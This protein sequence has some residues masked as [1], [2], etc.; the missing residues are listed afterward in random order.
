MEEGIL[1]RRHNDP[2]GDVVKT[3]SLLVGPQH[4]A[5][6]ALRQHAGDG[7][8]RKRECVS[9]MQWFKRAHAEAAQLT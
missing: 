9:R 4:K 8:S 5:L 6:A 7:I 1:E 2:H 3:L